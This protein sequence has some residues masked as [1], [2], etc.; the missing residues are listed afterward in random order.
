[1]RIP[2]LLFFLSLLPA[3]LWA[4]LPDSV[5]AHLKS[6][7]TEEQAQY[8]KEYAV[9]MY[10]RDKDLALEASAEGL[11]IATAS[12]LWEK[13]A[14][15]CNARGIIFGAY[16]E[17]DSSFACYARSLA[18]CD[19]YGF[20][21]VRMKVGMNL[22]SNYLY[23]GEY[24]KALESFHASLEIFENSNDSVGIANA[25][26]NIG[27][28]HLRLNNDPLGLSY[29]R[30]ALA[31]YRQLQMTSY[32]CRTLNM[33]GAAYEKINP[34]TSIYYL[35]Q[36]LQLLDPAENST[37]KSTLL[38]NLGNAFNKKGE[39]DK[40]LSAYQKAYEIT[41]EMN[42]VAHQITVL[43]NLGIIYN[44]KG[45]YNRALGYL[46][47]GLPLVEQNG[48]LHKELLLVERIAA[49][50]QGLGK[51]KEAVTYLQRQ[52]A[53][54]DSIFSLESAENI[55]E[56]E[57]K[58]EAAKKEKEIAVKDLDLARSQAQNRQ[59]VLLIILLCSGFV[60]LA[61]VALL[62]FR[63]YRYQQRRKE[64]LALEKLREYSQQIELLRASVDMQ[65][66]DARA[67]FPIHISQDDLNRNLLDPLSD[68][69]MDVLK[70]IGSGKTNKQIAEEIFVSENTVKFHLKNI[71]LKLDVQNRTEA[72]AKAGAMKLI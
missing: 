45:D 53:L 26:S 50:Y 49:A 20:E 67:S 52:I 41:L 66:A 34:D 30:K 16:R 46:F 42:D 51:Y 64:A 14:D 65:L 7:S 47:K 69:E 12:K 31:I 8:L 71:Y 25:T 24:E 58:Y 2:L 29:L 22:G 38:N 48:E 59:K 32:T 36:G 21:K 57:V 10:V 72:L 19:Q 27:M 3:V 17:L 6:I 55:Q 39:V 1:M 37:L 70:Q 18:L 5:Q 9:E 33:L 62:F 11:R 15:G 56:L 35:N 23:Q 13:V 43:S 4:A 44:R 28:C 61:L 40:A 63:N 54:N 68:R 60:V